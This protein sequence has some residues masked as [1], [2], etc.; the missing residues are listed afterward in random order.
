MDNYLNSFLR[1]IIESLTEFLPVSSTGHLFLF[2]S[3]FP[4]QNLAD[5][6]L[7]DDLFDIFIQSGAILSVLLIYF[8]TFTGNLKTAS[9]YIFKKSEDKAGFNF[10][11][12][13]AFGSLPVLLAGFIF[14]K[15]LDVI[16]SSDFLLLI[17][18]SAWLF[19]GIAIIVVEKYFAKNEESL[20]VNT[21][22][23]VSIKNA[24]FI[25]LIQCIA[26]IPG[27]S[28]S[29][30]TII[31]GRIFGLSRK[32]AAE[33]SFFLAVPVLIAAS[34]YK[35]LKYR[36][37]L[38]GEYLILLFLGFALTFVFCTAIIKWFLQFIKKHDFKLFGYYR[39]LLGIIV[40]TYYS[41]K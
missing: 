36:E 11:L 1:S 17:L 20:Q 4:F 39:I 26:L 5:A 9:L 40:I 19:G 15:Y 32:A 21:S 16:K 3:F 33:Y 35:L 22:E 8:N 6:A 14:K 28:R 37:L 10:Y 34:L 18:G 38:H 30:S 31:G 12:T 13:I 2:S 7:F 27:V 41:T 24:V 29:A 25:G 23:V